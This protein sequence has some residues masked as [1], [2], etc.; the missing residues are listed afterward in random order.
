MNL[1]VLP[2]P[3]TG[4]VLGKPSLG[5]ENTEPAGHLIGERAKNCVRNFIIAEPKTCLLPAYLKENN[6][7]SPL[8]RKRARSNGARHRGGGSWGPYCHRERCESR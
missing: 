2:Y 4:V 7:S 5:A 1:T 6:Q 8:P 3:G